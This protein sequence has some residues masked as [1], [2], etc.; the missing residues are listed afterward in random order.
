MC[1][2]RPAFRAP[3]TVAVIR[4]VCDE[5]PRPIREVNPDV[6]EPLCRLIERLHAK[7]PA[8]RPASA[9]EVAD[10]LAG[11]LADLSCGR[12]LT[13]GPTPVRPVGRRRWLWAAAALAVLSPGLAVGDATCNRLP[14]V[15]I[16]QEAARLAEAQRWA[17]S[18]AELP[19]EEQVEAVVN[20]LKERNPRFDGRVEPTFE[21]EVVIGLAF[22]TDGVSDLSPLRALTRLESVD[23]NGSPNRQGMVADLSPLRGLPL[24]RLVFFDNQVSDLS[25]LRGMPLKTLVFQRN[26]A[27]KDLT[28]LE[29]MSLEYLDFAHTSVTD[30]SPL[31]GMKLKH[32]ACDAT[33]VSDLSAL[34]GMALEALSVGYCRRVT[35]LSPLKGMPLQRLLWVGTAV[36]DTSPLQ[37]MPLKEVLCDFQRERD[38]EFLRPFKTL[39]KINGQSAAEFWKEVDGK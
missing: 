14:A 33:L 4:R 15:R 32:L 7:K 10:L 29:G 5:A 21:D 37:G 28:P 13:P 12:P 19:A 27:I 8:D 11:F 36:S 6:P 2:G 9:R 3:T 26:H 18:V 34:R 31:K 22:N 35:D 30:L 20:R 17:K 16:S 39:E 23:C 1:T 25:P 24:K 38:A